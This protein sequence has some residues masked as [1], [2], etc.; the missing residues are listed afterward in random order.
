L[1]ARHLIDDELHHLGVGTAQRYGRALRPRKEG[2][3][4][5]LAALDTTKGAE[6]YGWINLGCNLR[7]SHWCR[8]SQGLMRRTAA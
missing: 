6:V 4:P 8:L 3:C 7:A 1:L 5:F 2:E